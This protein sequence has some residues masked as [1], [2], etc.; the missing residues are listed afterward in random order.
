ML[1]SYTGD[2]RMPESLAEPFNGVDCV[3]HA[4]ALTGFATFPPVKD[5][6]DVNV[7]G[8]CF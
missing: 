8:I 1:K 7:G 4:A 6:E 3:I 2:V 5:M